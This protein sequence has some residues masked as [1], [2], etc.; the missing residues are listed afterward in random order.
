MSH[1]VVK[2]IAAMQFFNIVSSFYSMSIDF[3]KLIHDHRN[4]LSTTTAKSIGNA[5]VLSNNKNWLSII[6]WQCNLFL[7]LATN[8]NTIDDNDSKN[9]VDG[10][11][12]SN[13]KIEKSDF[14]KFQKNNDD[15]INYNNELILDDNSINTIINGNSAL[16]DSSSD[17]Q[18]ESKSDLSKEVRNIF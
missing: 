16:G 18:V 12:D 13:S 9:D 2:C 8:D 3:C 17:N 4:M 6:E 1:S 15:A 14:A 5:H 7:L 10:N 11:N